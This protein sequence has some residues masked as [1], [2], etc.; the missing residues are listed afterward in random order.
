M[1]VDIGVPCQPLRDK[2]DCDM[3]IT[4]KNYCTESWSHALETAADFAVIHST[5][6]EGFLAGTLSGAALWAIMEL[7]DRFNKTQQER[8]R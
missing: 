7:S 4:F 2:I 3:N 8:K 1:L 5:M 6:N